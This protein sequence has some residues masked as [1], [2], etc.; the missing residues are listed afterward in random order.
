MPEAVAGDARLTG[1]LQQGAE[2]LGLTLTSDQLRSLMLYLGLLA[3]WNRAYNLTAIRDT[4]E[5]VNLHLLD[6]LAV[7]Q[8]L[9]DAQRIIDVGTGP[10][11]PGVI[12]AIMHPGRQFTLLDSNGK[13]TRFLFQAKTALKLDNVTIV[14][15]RVEEFQ[16]PQPFDMITSR[17]FASL[18]DMV[19]WCR[20]LLAADGCFLAMKGQFPQDELDALPADIRLE[21][22]QALEVPG[23][24]G[25]RH[26]LRLVIGS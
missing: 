11:L 20:H 25:Q 9:G 17:A 2:R 10:G 5:M 13:K 26:L 1:K 3:K 15:G 19:H 12:L 23:V 6:S 16:P 22:S 8:H 4:N 14:N 21:N 7:S 18:Q 24:D